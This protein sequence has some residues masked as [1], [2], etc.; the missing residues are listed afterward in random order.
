MVCIIVSNLQIKCN[1]KVIS[2][3]AWTGN[4]YVWTGMHHEDGAYNFNLFRVFCL[5]Q[6]TGTITDFNQNSRLC[7]TLQR[8]HYYMRNTMANTAEI[9][10]GAYV[11]TQNRIS[12]QSVRWLSKALLRSRLSL[13]EWMVTDR[14]ISALLNSSTWS[15]SWDTSHIVALSVQ[16]WISVSIEN[17]TNIFKTHVFDSRLFCAVMGIVFHLNGYRS[18][19]GAM[20]ISKTQDYSICISCYVASEFIALSLLDGIC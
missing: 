11:R 1:T 2:K 7:V 4:W 6:N 19:I 15:M 9:S 17:D 10:H 3:W 20:V 18:C 16:W 8:Q 14:H 13:T 12:W 5:L